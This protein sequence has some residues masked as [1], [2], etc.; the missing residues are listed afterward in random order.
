M[1]VVAAGSL[2]SPA[3]IRLEPV[4]HRNVW[5]GRRLVDEWGYAAQDGPVGE[6]WGVSAH[7]HGDCCVLNPEFGGMTL[8][9]L[10]EARP[11]LFG[12]RAGEPGS[13]PGGDRF[14]LLVKVIDAARDL[15]VQVHPG[16]A[17][18]REHEAGSPGKAEC[19]YILDAPPGA[20]IVVGQ[21]ARTRAEFEHLMRAGDWGSLLNI[22]PVRAGS[23]LDV[24]PGTVHAIKAGTLLV[25]T[26]Q[27]SDVTYRLYDYGRRGPDGRLRELHVGKALDVIDFDAA[28]PI[29]AEVAVPERCGVTE[30]LSND[31]FTVL[32][33]RAPEARALPGSWP[34]LCVSVVSG[35]GT[36]AGEPVFKG[37]HMVATAG[38]APLILS[39][40]MELICSHV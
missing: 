21:R 38:S 22:V 7:P 23:F 11:D 15:S 18:A 12:G 17:Y 28:P 2:A 10:W 14:P 4:L 39:G 5:G 24:G 9:G 29:S 37:D 36:I 25:E 8:S 16:D 30:F 32:R 40:E 34:F 20:K 27:S 1:T 13:A 19:W 26:Q 3:L 31:R 33:A 35:S 6:C